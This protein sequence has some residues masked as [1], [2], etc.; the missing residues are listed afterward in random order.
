MKQTWARL[1][2]LFRA[3][4]L[5]REL[6][7]EVR[8]HID[9]AAEDYIDRGLPPN[10]AQRMAR[11][12][13]GAVAAS[14][15]AHR[16]SRGF[17]GLDGFIH[18]VRYAARALLGS[19]VFSLIAVAT[20]AI[21][22]GLNA[23]VFT[24]TN[25]V[26]FK[27]FRLVRQNERLV[28]ISNG[29][30]CIPYADFEDYQAK[31]KSFEGLA[32]VHG[33]SVLL[34]DP[35]GFAQTLQANE[36]TA[37]AFRVAG[38]QPMLGRDFTAGDV[39]PGASR[40]VILNFNFW[41]NHYGKDPRIV[42]REIRLD[43]EA[44]TVIG[45]MPEGFSFPQRVA[46]WVPLVRTAAV[47]RRDNTATWCAF[48]RLAPG[49]TFESAKRE[50]ETIAAR[51]RAAYP[52]DN[53]DFRPQVQHFNEFFIG[54]DSTLIYGLMWASVGFVLLIACTNLANLLLSRALA[55]SR[56]VSL[57][58]ALG[59]GRWRVIRQ[60]LI[61]SLMLSGL[62]AIFGW[63]LARGGVH[64]Y[65]LAMMQRAGWLVV[66]YRMDSRVLLYLIGISAATGI[67]FGLVPALRL[68]RWDI[69]T[70]LKANGRGST[71][72]RRTRRLSSTLVAVEMALAMVLLAGAGVMMRSF[73]KVY[74]ADMGVQTRQLLSADVIAP[75]NR[76]ATPESRIAF[77]DQLQ[78]RLASLPGVQSV[79]M[80]TALPAWEVQR[81]S[82]EPEGSV[83]AE[84]NRPRVRG[85]TITPGYFRTLAASVRSGRDFTA[86][87]RPG[88][89]PV[90]LVNEAL[91][92]Q[93]WPGQNPL[94]KRL[95][96]YERHAPGPWLTVIGV[97][98][99]IVQN[100]LTRQNFPPLIYSPY[101][102]EPRPEM[103]VVVRTQ[104]SP[105]SE[106][107]VVRTALL[108]VARG[109]EVYGPFPVDDELA[110][111]WTSGFQGAMFAVFAAVAVLL[112]SLGLY[113][114]IANSVA[115]RT[116]EIG[117]RVAVGATN[118]DVLALVCRQGRA[119]LL[120]GLSIGLAASLG[121]NQLLRAELVK[122]APA[123]PLALGACTAILVSFAL[124]GC[125]IPAWRAMRVDPVVALRN[126]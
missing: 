43:G 67:V 11:L 73:L 47:L 91:A 56:E 12:K 19:P 34:D 4:A 94:G 5:D 59:A 57:R 102:Q 69:N 120:A 114:V 54:P 10:D 87:D 78:A 58:I 122:V 25:A 35:G 80:T 68:S 105:A 71:S 41:K 65:D 15:D 88:S 39:R 112:A 85:L 53:P 1:L 126:D 92:K 24:I 2:A 86:A 50:I 111:F 64:L 31:A 55:R 125:L 7:D 106:I 37:N 62:G 17:P 63:W 72:T 70:A 84:N 101:L 29:G 95:R 13:F 27:G 3:P 38:V 121:V 123:D 45:V 115:Q 117:I 18:D 81:F 75:V 89:T 109:T 116:Q 22:V 21:G 82:Y 28:Y 49:V 52:L 76:Y 48:G 9:L 6:E 118:R 40:V 51:L 96:V 26:L 77:F 79:A 16:D 32:L 113:A 44:T 36:N 99:N 97:V 23:T 93:R 110:V 33:K 60:L 107:G 14:K 119:P 124:L 98:S 61:E 46:L 83:Y 42:G 74:N 100:D 8:T 108:A 20:L 104:L 66:D 30:C 90:V 103:R